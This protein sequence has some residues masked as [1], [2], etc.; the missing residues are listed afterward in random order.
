MKLLESIQ[1]GQYN[2]VDYVLNYLAD[3]PIVGKEDVPPIDYFHCFWVGSLSD[4]HL[5][6]LHSVVK[7]HPNVKIILWTT[8]IFELI[9]SMSAI[10]IKK[11]FKNVLEIIEIDKNLFNNANAE[12]MYSTFSMLVSSNTQSSLAYASDIIRFIVLEVYGGIWFDLDMI[13][14]RSLDTIK[15]KRYVSQWGT[16]ECGN[17]CLMRLEKN[18]A[19]IKEIYKKYYQP[20]YPTTTFK[21]N[22]DLDITILPSVFFDILWRKSED[23]PE[24]LCIKTFEDFF[25]VKELNLPS[26]LY[27]YHWHNRWSNSLPKFYKI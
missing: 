22:N 18:H 25:T 23:I 3:N 2:N 19:L 26:Q 20:F 6:S 5:M 9:S 24:H 1:Q 12:I 11:E 14:F 13:F 21:I 16:D 17:A 27:A 4:L 10:S 8:N 7:H 15:I